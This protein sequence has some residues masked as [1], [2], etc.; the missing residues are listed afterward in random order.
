[1]S[2]TQTLGALGQWSLALSPD[3]PDDVRGRVGFFGHLAVVR[4][5]VDVDT[6]GDALLA[7][8]RYVGVL[9]QKGVGDDL[10][11]SGSGMVFWLGDEDGKGHVIETAINLTAATLADSVTAVLPPTVTLGTVHP[12]SDTALRYTGSHIFQSPREALQIICDAFAVEFR[13]NNNATVDVGRPDQLYNTTAPDSIIVRNGAGSDV[14]L[15]AV[16]GDY[17]TEQAVHDYSTRV[18][19]LGQTTGEGGTPDTVFVTGA[20]DAPVVPYKDLRGN[21]VKMTRL[22]SESGQTEGS[23]QQRAQLQLNRFNRAA[24]ALT[25]DADQYQ[26][27]GVFVVG[28][29]TYVYDPDAGVQDNAREV[30]FRGEVLHP[31]LIRISSVTWPISDGHTVAFRDV[32]GAWLDLTRWVRWEASSSGGGLGTSGLTEIIVGDLPRSL[33]GPS[34]SAVQ[35]R[36]DASRPSAPDGSIPKTPTGL[37]LSTTAAQDTWGRD[38]A[39]VRGTWAAVTQNTDNTSLTDL[40]HY[41]MRY[42]PQFRAPGWHG[43]ELTEDLAVDF[44]AV[45]GLPYDVQV[46]AVD[47]GGNPSEWSGT[48][49]ITAAV[50]SVAPPAPADP[51]VSNYLGQLRIEYTGTSAAGTA[52]PADALTVEVHVG[53]AASF[54]AEP[55]T[56]VDDLTP[57]GRGVSLVTAPYGQARWVRLVAVDASGNRGP[58]SAAVSGSTAQVVSA[59]IFDGAVG[60]SKLANLAV[61]TA[62]INDLAVNDAKVGNLSVGKLTAGT[63]TVDVVIS[64]RNT[65]ALTGARVEHNALGFQGFR[66]DGSKWL[67]LTPSE[68]LLTGVV[69]TQDTGRR[70]EIGAGGLWGQIR[71]IAPDNKSG[72]MRAVTAGANADE[73][74][75]FGVEHSGGNVSWNVIGLDSTEG[76]AYRTKRHEFTF[77]ERLMVYQ[78][79]NRGLDT[80]IERFRVDTQNVSMRGGSTATDATKTWNFAMFDG[81]VTHRFQTGALYTFG[82][83]FSGQSP[84]LTLQADDSWGVIL[85]AQSNGSSA[86]LDVRGILD[87]QFYGVRA[88][89][90]QQNSDMR[91][92]HDIA[93]FT[94]GSPLSL[95]AQVRPRQFKF[96]HGGDKPVVDADGNVTVVE[97]PAPAEVGVIAQELPAFMRGGSEEHGYS[98]DLGKGLLLALAAIQ[99]LDKR[100]RGGRA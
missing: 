79:G 10:T 94:I 71:F 24:R 78:T 32:N 3:T 19:L 66:A 92:K 90:F 6:L 99:E 69:K 7:Q 97:G 98:V 72:F 84:W 36:V 82:D 41:E 52:M 1:M 22:I 2:V 38:I 44:V 39:Y 76:A 86:T 5:D 89:E 8:A 34:G 55:A 47:L 16:S 81:K 54:V 57:F 58:S 53:T 4:G 65:T 68:S 67:S 73:V 43:S 29:G 48:A 46:R 26:A 61:T 21:P 28:D 91:D 64:G 75:Q 93:D 17:A 88:S 62:K 9:R 80:P 56:K 63:Q 25:V 85:R 13:V 27:D 30:F 50:D 74:L 11:L 31:D 35:D 14:D 77:Q 49:S 45:N 12:L 15:T 95:V 87:N 20:A 51:V 37:T 70:I 83:G 100:T 59:D 40:S 33:T 23:V 42:R 96:N 18:L 60:S